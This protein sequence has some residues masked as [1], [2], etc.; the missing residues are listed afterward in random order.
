MAR[1]QRRLAAI[2]CADVVGFSRLLGMDEADTLARLRTLRRELVDPK[3]AESGGRIVK[4]TGDGLLVEFGSVVDAVRCA[5]AVQQ[6]MIGREPS[7]PADRRIQFRFGVHTGD[8]VID[9]DDILGDGVNVAA[10]LETLAEPGGVCVSGRVQEDLAGKLELDLRDGGEQ[11][12]KNI[13]RPV[14]V[15]RWAPSVTANAAST[16]LR[17]SDEPLPLPDK[18]SIAVLP[19]TNM[20]GDPEQEYFADGMVEDIITAL[21]R[22]KSLFVIARNSSFIYKGRAVDIKQ[23]GRELGVRYVLEGSVR[24]AGGRLRITGQLIDSET[25]AHIWA[26][27]FEGALEDIFDLQDQITE[28]VVV[29]IAPRVEQAEIA[30]AN[31][32]SASNLDAYDCYL[33]GLA[34]RFPTTKDRIDEALRLFRRAIE[35][36]PGFTSA[37]GMLAVCFAI[38]KAFGWFGDTP[39]E[40][41]EARQAAREAVEHGH[42]DALAL[43]HGAYALAYVLHDLRSGKELADRA[44]ALN[45]NLAAVWVQSGFIRLWTGEPDVARENFSRAIRLSPLDFTIATTFAGMAHACFFLDR[46]DEA[47]SWALK[48]LQQNPQFHAA[49]RILAAAAAYAGMDELAQQ[50]ARQLLALDPAFR[51]SQLKNYLGPYQVPTFLAKYAEGLRRAGLPE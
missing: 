31:R 49:L 28:K 33:R 32:R 11:T 12:L 14:R 10:R 40:R 13:A 44:V 4:T 16:L 39:E 7:V 36:D 2:V 30:R 41:I 38:R 23:V 51:V 17:P 47:T 24:K 3:I 37:Y 1:E 15:W 34:C 45:P 43:I 20:S 5:V 35:L 29:A 22:F 25:G 21:S 48:S 27:R 50:T 9:G 42:D 19:F 6:E 18:P 26:D 46:H 8:I